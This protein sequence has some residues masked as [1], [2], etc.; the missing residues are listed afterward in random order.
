MRSLPTQALL[1]LQQGFTHGLVGAIFGSML[2]RGLVLWAEV[3]R[4]SPATRANRFGIPLAAGVLCSA[5]GIQTG[6]ASTLR[7]I[8]ASD[9]KRR[10]ASKAAPV[11]LAECI[12]HAAADR[13]VIA[14]DTAG[15]C[16][17]QP[18]HA[19]RSYDVLPVQVQTG[20]VPGFVFRSE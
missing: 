11:A 10:I 5:V 9:Q 14:S 13:Y 12:A 8:D 2:A 17:L 3:L 18:D 16:H 6:V 4:L 7:A 19:P 15:Q 1:C 20:S